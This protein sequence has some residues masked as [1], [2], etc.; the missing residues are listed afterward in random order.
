MMPPPH[1]RHLGIPGARTSLGA[2]PHSQGTGPTREPH[3]LCE[4]DDQWQ[5]VVLDEVQQLLLADFSL[6]VVAAFVKLWM[7]R[8]P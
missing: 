4:L 1:T 6:E 3:L 2:P 8:G 5:L 7:Q